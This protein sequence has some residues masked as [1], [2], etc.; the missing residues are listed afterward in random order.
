MKFKHLFFLLLFAWVF[1]QCIKTEDNQNK[2]KTPPIVS[3]DTSVTWVCKTIEV[4]TEPKAPRAVGAKGKFWPVGTVLKVGFLDGTPN[5]IATV[6]A[7]AVEWFQYANLGIDWVTDATKAD[8]RISFNPG[9]GAWSYVG[10][11][12]KLVKTGP[13]MN[14]GWQAPDAIKHE[15]GHAL[16]LYHEHQNPEGG[17]C[18][19]E[20]NVIKDLSGPPNNWSVA[21]IR[22]NV[23][24]KHD[25][26]NVVTTPWDK[27]SIMHYGIPGTW[28]CNGIG[29]P[30]GKTISSTDR[31]FIATIYPGKNPG[32][33]GVTLTEAQVNTI[34]QTLDARAIE[35]DT[36]AARLKRT[37]SSIGKT[38]GK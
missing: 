36:M 26:K 38:L 12:N 30:G 35:A 4:P 22:Y 33:Q 16:G 37:R 21:M 7:N 18:W 24:D 1:T 23:L 29:I 2:P 9:S 14:L 32:G 6:K 34:L 27:T 31:T 13:T 10:T 5:Q 3:T 19:V 25:P 17:I 11:D 15:F 20:S 8:L 28:V